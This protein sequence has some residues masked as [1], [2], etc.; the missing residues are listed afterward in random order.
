MSIWRNTDVGRL[1]MGQHVRLS[2]L[3]NFPFKSTWDCQNFCVW[4]LL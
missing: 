1:A 2:Q 4:G 3:K